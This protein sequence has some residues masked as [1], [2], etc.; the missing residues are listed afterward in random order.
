[1]EATVHRAKELHENF[2]HA[3]NVVRRHTGLF[4]KIADTIL[5]VLGYD[6]PDGNDATQ[7]ILHQG[8]L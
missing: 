7:L 8:E 3:A 6:F 5:S 4:N 2:E 1:M